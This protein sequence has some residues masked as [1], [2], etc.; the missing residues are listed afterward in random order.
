MNQSTRSETQRVALSRRDFLTLSTATALGGAL[1]SLTGCVSAVTPRTAP[2]T[3]GKVGSQLY[4]W[5]QYYQ[6]EGKNVN[7]QLAE[8][9]SALRDAGYDYAEGNLD[10]AT[11]GNNL[12]F[13]ELLRTKGLQPVSLY[14]GG[15]LHEAGKAEDV[16]EQLVT[17]AIAAKAAGFSVINCNPDP[18]GREKT[19]AE[20]HTQIA[21]LKLLGVELR[22]LGM[23]LG[24]HH[25]L[26]EMRNGAREFEF[27]FA[28]S[29]PGVVDFCFDVHWIYRGGMPPMEALNKHGN[30]IVCW[31]LRQ[32]RERIWWEDLDAGDVDYTTI[33]GCVKHFRLPQVYTVE[34][35]LEPGTKIT[36]SVV[37]NHARSREYVRRTFGV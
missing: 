26:P 19:D 4:G 37:E 21:A 3:E 7:Q 8:V 15:R 6:R 5:G 11:P 17:S 9:L 31:H 16:V 1:A 35:A 27:N 34:L 2:V 25:H 13:A 30:R 36:R 28:Q 24:I 20:L 33:A 22:K 32:S 18:I 10:V 12:R 14:T 29:D 23:R